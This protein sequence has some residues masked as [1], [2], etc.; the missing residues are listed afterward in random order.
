MFWKHSK[1][2]ELIQFYPFTMIGIIPVCDGNY[3]I[4]VENSS[5]G[6]PKFINTLEVTYAI[7]SKFI[8]NSTM[9][10]FR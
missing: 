1:R 5:F 2:H 3:G 7:L 6:L 4:T 10:A 9:K 8:I